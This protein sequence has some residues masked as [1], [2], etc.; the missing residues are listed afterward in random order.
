[1]GRTDLGLMASTSFGASAPSYQAPIAIVVATLE[2]RSWVESMMVPAISSRGEELLVVDHP[3]GR[4]CS[5]GRHDHRA[6]SFM[7]TFPNGPHAGRLSAGSAW[8]QGRDEFVEHSGQQPPH[9]EGR[10]RSSQAPSR[11][12]HRHSHRS[13]GPV[14]LD[15]HRGERTQGW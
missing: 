7:L 14:V 4:R 1:M 3:E 10:D 5:M 6:G 15:D 12:F 13:R 8:R 11:E 9:R 2:G